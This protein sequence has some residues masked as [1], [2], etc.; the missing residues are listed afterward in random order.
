MPA[1]PAT[2]PSRSAPSVDYTWNAESVFKDRAAWTKEYDAL[3]ELL[4]TLS[5]YR[6]RIAESPETLL[7]W[8]DHALNLQRRVEV[9]SFY[10]FMHRECNANDSEAAAM[11]SQSGSLIAKFQAALAFFEPELLAIPR[12]T[13]DDWLSKEKKLRV[14]QHYVDNLFRRAA[15]VRSAEVEETVGLAM[16]MMLSIETVN[17]ELTNSD[18]QFVPAAGMN[19]KVIDI[20]QTN[21]ETLMNHPDRELRRTAWERYHDGYVQHKNTLAANLSLAF[22]RDIF[23]SRVRRHESS[24]KAALHES[25]I[26]ES[27]YRS[28]LDTFKKNLPTWHRYWAIR[29]RALELDSLAPYDVWAPVAKKQPVVPYKQAVE[30]I[31]EAM[32]P[33]GK[34]YSKAIRRGCLEERWV[35]VYPTKGKRQGAFSSGAY[36]THPFIMMS[37]NDSLGDLSTLAHELG[38]SMHSYLTWKNQ[39]YI[40][41]GYS[42]FVAEVA[43]NFNQAITRAYLM[44]EKADDSQFQIALIE[45]AMDNFHRY[46]F[47]MP[48]LARFEL[49]VHERIEAGKGVTADDMIALMADLFEEGYGGEM[50]IDA[51]M[52]QRIGMTWGTFGHLYMNYYVFQYATGISA[53]HALAAPILAGDEA[54][55]ERYVAF[56]S[57]GSSRYPVDALKAAGVDMTTPAAVE[58]TFATLSKYVDKLAELTD[59]Y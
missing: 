2:A 56:L 9:V 5:A 43:S 46:F 49:E 19:G 12:E 58:E 32:K 38:H 29:R 34:D 16:D 7:E 1:P 54:A 31:S 52:R 57:S 42:M 33:L 15:H 3:I 11:S 47:Q 55:A 22:K 21:Y 45:E 59:V 8:F 26:P 18:M 30:W 53:A 13:L 17:S 40:Y 50:A 10:A 35:D 4:P 25:N 14:Y 44:K 20:T 6:G 39:P 23:L 24:L 36:G 51:A 41:G 28:L 37:Y 48:T 27:V